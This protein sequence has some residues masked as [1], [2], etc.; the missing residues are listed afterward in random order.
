MKGARRPLVSVNKTPG[1]TVL[2]AQE[3]PIGVCAVVQQVQ[4]LGAEG[5]GVDQTGILRREERPGVDVQANVVGKV[6]GH[7]VIRARWMGGARRPR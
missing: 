1:E 3:S 5:S 7:G 4:L 2:V 6:S